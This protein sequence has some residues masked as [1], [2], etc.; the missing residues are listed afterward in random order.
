M[1]SW[2]PPGRAAVLTWATASEQNN[3]GFEVQASSDGR[4]FQALAFVAGAGSS[5]SPH[6]YAYTDR[7]AGKTGLRYYRLRQVD[8]DDKASFSPVRTV[9]FGPEKTLAVGAVPNPFDGELLIAAEARTAQAAPLT[10]FDAVG[11]AVVRRW[12]EVAAGPN[13]LPVTGLA[14]LPAGT[15]FGQL[16][17]DGQLQHFKA[18]RK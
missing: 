16:L 6:R 5:S 17:L 7:E 1:I 10:L 8:T 9:A 12:L 15:Y 13:R 14:G 4:A 2:A 3:R 11:R 18:I